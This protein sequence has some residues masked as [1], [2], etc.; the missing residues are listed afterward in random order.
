MLALWSGCA[1]RLNTR[2]LETP[3][4]MC[5]MP[6]ALWNR[7]ALSANRHC[8]ANT[9]SGSDDPRARHTEPILTGYL[10]AKPGGPGQR[11]RQE[12]ACGVRFQAES[13]GNPHTTS[14]IG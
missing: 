6:G 1:K 5:G 9:G 14:A 10:L 11:Q 12:L 2:M 13:L 7:L 4:S 3:Q 8:D